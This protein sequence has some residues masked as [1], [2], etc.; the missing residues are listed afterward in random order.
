MIKRTAGMAPGCHAPAD[1]PSFVDHDHVKMLR[2]K[3]PGSNQTGDTGS[4]YQYIARGLHLTNI[5]IHPSLTRANRPDIVG[6]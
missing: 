1:P 3:S 4:N 5:T 6:E 2:G